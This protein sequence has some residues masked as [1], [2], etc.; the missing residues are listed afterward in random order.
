MELFDEFDCELPPTPPAS[1]LELI[2]ELPPI[3]PTP[4]VPILPAG[5]ETPRNSEVVNL[6]A[7]KPT[8]KRGPQ[9]SKGSIPPRKKKTPS[10]QWMQEEEKRCFPGRYLTDPLKPTLN[11]CTKVGNFVSREYQW[12]NQ[13]FAYLKSGYHTRAYRI[14]ESTGFLLDQ[15]SA[16]EMTER[17][18]TLRYVYYYYDSIQDRHIVSVFCPICFNTFPLSPLTADAP[19]SCCKE[20][21]LFCALCLRNRLCYT[22][23]K[24]TDKHHGLCFCSAPIIP[25]RG[26][27]DLWFSTMD[28]SSGECKYREPYYYWNVPL[29][30]MPVSFDKLKEARE[31]I[32]QP[33][34][35]GKYLE[36]PHAYAHKLQTTELPPLIPTNDIRHENGKTLIFS[37]YL[38]A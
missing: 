24:N 6:T 20:R 15:V 29:Q 21:S 22:I 17:M 3:S 32:L 33:A 8:R 23:Q 16:H 2:P 30:P 34:S 31:H 37:H 9:P 28:A 27:V 35:R 26:S 25:V 12:L 5:P 10:N 7:N 38:P 11:H 4:T 13:H 1:V 14:H 36:L 19:M 18:Y